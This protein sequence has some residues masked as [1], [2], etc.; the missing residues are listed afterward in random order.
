MRCPYLHILL[1]LLTTFPSFAIA[2]SN[3]PWQGDLDA[4]YIDGQHLSFRD[5][6]K[7][8]TARIF[9]NYQPSDPT[10]VSWHMECHFKDVPTS[11]NTFTAT[12]FTEERFPYTYVYRLQPNPQ[13]QGV[14]LVRDTHLANSPNGSPQLV[15]STIIAQQSTKQLLTFW[16]QLLI[17]VDY[18]KGQGVRLRTFSPLL[19]MWQSNWV[20]TLNGQLLWQMSLTTKFTAKKKLGYTYLLPSLNKQG[21]SDDSPDTPSVH[22]LH[23]QPE[24]IG[25]V[26]LTLSAP[27]LL[28]DATVTCPGFQPT[29][30]PGDKP[31]TLIVNLGAT[32]APHRTYNFS[33]RNLKD[34]EGRLVELDFVVETKGEADGATEI[35]KGLFITE[36]MAAPPTQGPLQHIKYI[37]LYN[38]S[39]ATKQLGLFTLLYGK[40][41]Y[42]LPPITLAD[43]SFAVLYLSSDPYPTTTATL[44]PMDH[45]PNL[46][47]SFT[48]TLLDETGKE[49]D[50]VQF[51]YRL[52]GQGE[53]TSGA[54]V[55]RVAYHP[56]SWRRSK[57]PSGGTPGSHTTLLP[58]KEVPAGAVVINEL[59]LSPPSTGEKYIELY[60]PSSQPINLADLYLSYSNKEESPTSSSWLLVK[61]DY[62]LQPHNYV[63]LCPYPEALPRLYTQYS[64]QTFVERIDFPSLSST[65]TELSLRSHKSNTLIDQ[66][67]Y[68]RQWLGA[69][70]NERS[71]YSLERI[72]STTDGT[73][74]GSW[75]RAHDNGTQPHTGGT[76]GVVNSTD[77]ESFIEHPDGAYTPWPDDPNLDDDQ[78][79]A[80]LP[81]YADQAKL[82]LYTITGNPIGTYRGKEILTML[83]AI[84][85]GQ[86]HLPTLILLLHI[87]IYDPQ[88]EPSL[89]TYSRKWL[90]Y[91]WQ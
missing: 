44:V 81:L 8:G 75:R 54:S 62:L 70:T 47:N 15:S 26:T 11:A 55:E 34:T 72:G 48:L 12:L 39:G 3:T 65:Y 42:P 31:N 4:Y 17:D 86:A 87:E 49:W 84:K 61:D 63:V 14:A 36:I 69:T 5:D 18:R 43:Q 91:R 53:I 51:S 25:R 56:S 32:F 37:E 29:L 50:R 60:N 19:G 30:M 27:V 45:F 88:Q 10:H 24:D 35:P 59:L 64:T 83:Q 58:Y 46:G 13:Y 6:G 1:G 20:K 23:F 78:V 77:G 21:G 68:R 33:I 38:N 9:R 41:K 16:Q 2:Q 57:H 67:T 40:S 90:H 73:L 28:K 82:E 89:L 74:R 22:I 52:Y 79:K 85:T 71:G 7:A 66:S 80:L 76:P